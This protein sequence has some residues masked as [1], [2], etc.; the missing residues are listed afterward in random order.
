MNEERNGSKLLGRD[1]HP[2]AFTMW[3]AGAG[4]KRGTTYGATDDF[5]YT[6]TENKMT[7]R[8]LQATILHQLGLDAKKLSYAFQGL[9]QR[10]IGPEGTA[11]VPAALLG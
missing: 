3:M 4:I 10:L 8:D 9:N 2:D 6:V 7:V 5:G 11:K 1:H